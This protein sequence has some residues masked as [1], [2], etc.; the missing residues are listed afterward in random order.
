M[1]SRVSGIHRFVNYLDPAGVMLGGLVAAFVSIEFA[2]IGAAIASTT[3][4]VAVMLASLSVRK[5]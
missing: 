3:L 2:L 5:L 4:T 1:R